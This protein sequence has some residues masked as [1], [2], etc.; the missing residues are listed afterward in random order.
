LTVRVASVAWKLRRI[1]R[2]S[3]F[4][5]HFHDLI[6]QAHDQGADLVVFPE[7]MI[8][9]LLHL[10]PQLVEHEVPMYLSQYSDALEEWVARISASSNMTLVGGS[11]FRRSDHGIVNASPLSEPSGPQGIAE[12]NNLTTYEREVW[13]LVPGSGLVTTQDRQIG[14]TVCYDSEF[15]EAGRV[16]A[17]GGVLI[18]CVPAFT[19]TVYGYQRV[20]WCC[21]ARAIENQIFVA[22]ASLLGSLGR[23]PVVE[24]YGNSAIY[25]P[26]MEGFPISGVLAET[27]LHEEGIA[28]ADCDLELLL[29]IRQSGDVRNWYDRN[30]GIWRIE[31]RS[32]LES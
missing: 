26:S 6:S 18:H 10:E 23:E 4:F 1:R 19:E 27:P 15:P 22:H 7:L 2:D 31:E 9:E 14:I 32:S 13:R 29:D 5:G 24:T 25:A 3:E 17:E 20:R 11:H 8:L 21:R 16:L 30:N 28:V 12:K